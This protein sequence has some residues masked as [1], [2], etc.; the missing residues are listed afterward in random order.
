MQPICWRG[1]KWNSCNSFSPDGVLVLDGAV[2]VD[3]P[4]CLQLIGLLMIYVLLQ[5][6]CS[7]KSL[8]TLFAR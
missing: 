2:L 1:A 7:N 3:K 8:V 5:I 6:T 4:H